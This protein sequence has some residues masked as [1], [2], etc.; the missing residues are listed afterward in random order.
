MCDSLTFHFVQHKGKL[1]DGLALLRKKSMEINN[2]K[3]HKSR[4]IFAN[5]I[6]E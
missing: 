1:S 5:K 6:L 3:K 2:G 4:A